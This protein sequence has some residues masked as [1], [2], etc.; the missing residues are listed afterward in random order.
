MNSKDI[1]MK[2]VEFVKFLN[3]E[4]NNR[5]SDP[6]PLSLHTKLHKNITRSRLFSR[7]ARESFE[8]SA[9]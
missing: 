9:I 8:E 3:M 6:T 7:T 1:C 5:C 2:F 4:N